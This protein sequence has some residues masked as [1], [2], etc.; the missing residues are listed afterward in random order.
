MYS[1]ARK[2]KDRLKA[3]LPPA[4]LL[5]AS[6][7]AG[8]PPYA[9]AGVPRGGD[10]GQ[11]GSAE[12]GGEE[13]WED[14]SGFERDGGQE[15]PGTQAYG[16]GRSTYAERIA[17]ANRLLARKN[18][19]AAM[20]EFNKSLSSVQGY[21]RRKIYVY[22]RLGWLSLKSNDPDGALGFYLAAIGQAEN[23]EDRGKFTVNA[24]RGAAYCQALSGET[25]DAEENYRTAL[26]LTRDKGARRDIEK[27]LSR[28]KPRAGR[29]GLK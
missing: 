14:G 11:A 17:A 19:R 5:L 3:L 18:Y 16:G 6:L 12:E 10:S 15:D 8:L 20:R 22:E 24:Y 21:D 7:L 29:A 26:K 28:L 27:K 25:A 2:F 4:W 23:L 1:S 13:S 9:D